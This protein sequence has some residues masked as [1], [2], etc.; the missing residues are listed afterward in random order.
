MAESTARLADAL[1]G[2]PTAFQRAWAA[3]LGLTA[4]E[5]DVL[6]EH[7]ELRAAWLRRARAE[8]R[9]AQPV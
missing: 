3:A 8:P 2:E 7:S 9:A 4:S 5:L 1:P 6:A